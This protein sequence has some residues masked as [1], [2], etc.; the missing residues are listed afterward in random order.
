M[1]SQPIDYRAVLADLEQKK[2]EIES[3][4]QA[5]RTLIGVREQPKPKAGPRKDAVSSPDR[6]GDV[7]TQAGIDFS[8]MTLADAAEVYLKKV[9]QPQTVVEIAKGLERLGFKHTSTYFNNTVRA[10]LTRRVGREV[11][12]FRQVKKKWGLAE[13]G[14]Q[15]KTQ[16]GEDNSG[17]NAK[18]T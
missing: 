1:G 6:P 2:E 4:I 7:G 17:N 12:D 16:T 9:R 10:A 8:D 5:V 14:R 13:W 18:D 11:G 3:A 15:S